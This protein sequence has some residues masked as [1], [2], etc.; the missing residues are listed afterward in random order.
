M[1]KSLIIVTVLAIM[2]GFVSCK[3][4]TTKYSAEDLI[5]RWQAPSD[6]SKDS[7][8]YRVFLAEAV[9][10]ETE[11]RYGYEWDMGDHEG[12]DASQG[13]YEDFLMTP[14]SEDGEF[15]GNGWYH[16]K[17]ATNG[18]L[19]IINLMHNG[20]AEV[21]KSYTVT[22]LTN[23]SLTFKDSFGKTHSFTRIK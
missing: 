21:V 1:K 5:G 14:T 3:K 7:M 23:S 8:Q 9:P 4:T 19:T 2:V 13:T 11:Y 10:S 17:L 15:H 12:W 18:E 20:G 16:W 22:V 6:Y